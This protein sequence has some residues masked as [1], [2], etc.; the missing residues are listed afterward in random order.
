MTLARFVGSAIA[1]AIAVVLWTILGENSSSEEKGISHEGSAGEPPANQVSQDIQI[2]QPSRTPVGSPSHAP[3]SSVSAEDVPWF[4]D[5]RAEVPI[6][7]RTTG[8]I[9]EHWH[10]DLMPALYEIRPREHPLFARVRPEDDYLGDPNECLEEYL[11]GI[12]LAAFD[13]SWAPGMQ[14]LLQTPKGIPS[15]T[16]QWRTSPL[17]CLMESLAYNPLGL[18]STMSQEE[19]RPIREAVRSKKAEMATVAEQYVERVRSTLSRELASLSPTRKPRH[20]HL[21]FG[22]FWGPP[23]PHSG[24][25]AVMTGFNIYVSGGDST[26]P[27]GSFLGSYVLDLFEHE[28]FAPEA[29]EMSRYIDNA[30]EELRVILQGLE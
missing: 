10:G 22:P 8:E 25:D 26:T 19:L 9:L 7:G 2:D 18:G 5:K 29:V 14:G 15:A 4:I 16:G 3:Q 13:A 27:C 30:A 6:R 28:E 1:V 11:A 24:F 12:L 23:H 21:F 17:D 20:G